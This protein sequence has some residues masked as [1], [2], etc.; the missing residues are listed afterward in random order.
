MAEKIETKIKCPNCLTKKEP[1]VSFMMK[2]LWGR[3]NS[4]PHYM[5]ICEKCGKSF[6]DVNENFIDLMENMNNGENK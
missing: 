5:V 4:N 6:D 1:I 2:Q 3:G